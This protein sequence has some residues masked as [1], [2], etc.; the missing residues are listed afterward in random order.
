VYWEHS[1]AVENER[2]AR[3][4][5]IVRKGRSLIERIAEQE[6]LRCDELPTR[7]LIRPKSQGKPLDL[8]DITYAL[9]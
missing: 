2:G 9:Q 1:C 8:L 4:W 5:L 6:L 7:F 3:F